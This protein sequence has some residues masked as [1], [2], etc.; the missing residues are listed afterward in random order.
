MLASPASLSLLSFA[1]GATVTAIP[2]LFHLNAVKRR[3]ATAEQK[4]AAIH[5]QHVEAGKQSHRAEK[6]KCAETTRALAL[7]IGR[8]DL[9]E[10]INDP[11][12][13]TGRGVAPVSTSARAGFGSSAPLSHDPAAAQRRRKWM[14]RAVSRTCR[15]DAGADISSDASGGPTA[16]IR[17]P[18]LPAETAR[19]NPYLLI[20]R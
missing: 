5:S 10:R 11:L 9:A 18:K 19:L 13:D 8:P 14:D 17:P 1:A 20:S 15:Q 16:A 3:L 6:A 2:L 4:L 7:S 12:D